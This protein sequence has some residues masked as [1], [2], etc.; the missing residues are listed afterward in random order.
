MIS[1]LMLISALGAVLRNPSIRRVLAA[2]IGFSLAEWATWI[3]ILVHAYQRGGATEAGIVA[4]VQLAPSAVLAP[5]AAVL[6]DRYRRDRALLVAYLAQAATMGLTAAALLF[7]LPSPLVY[8]AATA[9]ATSITLTRPVQGAILPSLARTPAELTAANVATGALETGTIL[10]GPILAGLG[11][12]AWGAGAVF[13]ASAVVTLAGAVLVSGVRPVAAHVEPGAPARQPIR[14]ALGGVLAGFAMLA[15]EERPRSVVVL[16]GFA[17]MLWG[18]LDVLLVVLALDV[19][20][21][22]EAGVGYLNAAM[23]AGGLI[24]AAVTVTLIGRPRLALPFIA[25]IV[26]WALPLAVIGLLASPLFAFGLLAVAGLGRIVMD[27]A[28]RTL[29]QRVAPDA[30]LARVFGLLEGVHMGSLALGSIAAPALIG[31]AGARG[32]FV[33]AGA[34][35]LAVTA[36]S[37]RQLMRTDAAGATN[38]RELEMLRRIPLFAPLPPHAIERLAANL[39]PY[40]VPAGAVIIKQGEPGDR[41]YI[42]TSGSVHVS[43]DGRVVRHEEPGE[44]FGEIALLRRVPRTA[45]VEAVTPTELVALERRIFLEAITGQPQSLAAAE[46]AIR[47]R[48]GAQP[49][50]AG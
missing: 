2:F 1:R 5:L 50:D 8:A 28:G 7:D 21:L 31:L 14:N 24:G 20:E 42:I 32:A 16:L 22:G 3:A 26:L 36:L 49:A 33:V 41:F 9:A 44:W 45:T 12:A 37:A 13:G 6:G 48:L 35:L 39:V 18:A 47:E 17:A 46:E 19:L 27:V 34:A 30:M 29:L 11:L 40:S 23:G 25:A 15:R 38:P 4:L 43:V 10:V